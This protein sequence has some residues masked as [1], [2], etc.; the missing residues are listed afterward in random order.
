MEGLGLGLILVVVGLVFVLLVRILLRLLLPGNQTSANLSTSSLTYL[1][2]SDQKDAVIIIQGGGRVEYL[3]ESARRLFGFHEDDQVDLERLTR[4]V[5]PSD[6]FLY[7]L[8]KESQKRISIGAQLTEATSYHVPGLSPLM[9]VVLRNLD[10]APAFSGGEEGQVSASILRLITDFGQS[11]SSNL[12]LKTTLQAILENVGRLISADTIELKVWDEANQCLTPYR[13]EGRSGEPRTLRRVE[14]S[15]FGNYADTLLKTHKPLLLSKTISGDESSTNGMTEPY[16]VRSYIGMPLMDGKDLVGTLEVGQSADDS[17][18]QH[19]LELLHLVAGQAAVAIHN[20]LLYEAEEQRTTELTSLANLAQAVSVSQD[21]K[22]LFERLVKS[23]SPLFDVEIIGFLLYDEGKRTLEGQIPFQGLPPHIVE[24]YRTNIP[25]DKDASDIITS[26]K[27][28]TTLNAAEDET[29]ETLGIRNLAQAASLRDSVLMPLLSGRRLLGFMQLSNHREG[30]V[31][32]SDEELRLI[33][34]VANQA[35]AIIENAVLVQQA[36]QRAY[37]SDA[38]RRI[39]SL[40]ASSASVDE[41][42]EHSVRELA[43]LFQADSAVIFLLDEQNGEL[44]LHTRS[45]FGVEKEAA[46]AISHMFV[47]DAQYRSTVSGSQKPFIS[48]RLSSDRRVLPV[49]RPIVTTLHMESSMVVPLVVRERSLGELM[50]GSRRPEFFNSYDLQVVTTA[51]GQLAS[52]LESARLVSQTDERLRSRVDQLTAIMRVSRELNASLDVDKLL[53]LVHDES[54]RTTRADC[55]T[56]LLFDRSNANEKPEIQFSIGCP[57]DKNLNKLLGKVTDADEALVIADFEQEEIPASHDGIHSAL[58]VPIRKNGDVAGVIHLHASRPNFFNDDIVDLVQTLAVQASIALNTASQYQAEHQRAELLR[59]R[60]ETMSSLTEISY[61]INFEQSLEQQLRNIGNAIRDATPFQAVLFSIFEPDNGMLRRVTGIGFSQEV[62]SELLARKQPLTSI[63]Q[64]LKPEF[65]VSHSYFI[66]ADE[67]PVVPADVHMVTLD[68]KEE[69][70]LENAWDPDDLLILPLSDGQGNPLGLL[71]LD[72][73]NDGLRPDKATIETIEIFA[74]QASLVISNTTRFSDLR[75]RVETLSSGLQRQQRLLSVSQNDLP[76]LLRKDLE[77]TLSIQNLDRRAQRVRAGL[78]I[79]ESVSRQLDASSAL[80]AL[81][82]EVLTQLG[83]SVALVAEEGPEGPRL[84]HILG[85]VPRATNPETLFGQRNPLR[86]CLQMG[87]TILAANEDEADEWLDT[88]LLSG[89]HAKAFICLPVIVQ[90]KTVAAIMAISPEPLPAFTDEDRQVYYQI[91]RQ[92]S[93]ILQNI[94]LLSETR[95]R[96]QEVDLLLDFSRQI[97]GLTPKEIIKALLESARRVI[98]P[99]AHAG[100]VLL[101][102]ENT[103]Q[104]M[105]QTCAGYADNDSLMKIGYRSGEAL[106]GMVFE[107]KSPHR[108]D[109]LNFARDYALTAENLFLYRQATGGRLPVSTLLIPVVTGTQGLG[110]LV[111][112]NF[113]T[114]AAFKPEDETLLLSLT[115]QVALSL[116]NVRLVQATQE[117]AGQLQALNDVATSMTSSLRSEELIASLL[118]Q[119]RPVLPFDTATLLLREKELLRVYAARGFTDSEQRLG[120]TV[121]VA[122]STLFQEMIRVRRPISVAD[123]R[124]D[125]RFPQIETPRLSWLGI[126]LISKGEVIGVITLEKWQ[127]SFYTPDHMQVA[128][129]FAGQAAVA[130]ENAR[131]YEDSVNRAGELDQRSQ[132][133]ALLN[134]FSSQMSGLLDADEIQKVTAEELRKAFAAMRVSVARLDGRTATWTFSTPKSKVELPLQ[135]PDAPI[136]EQLRESLGVFTGE[137]FLREPAV[138]SLTSMLGAEA[139]SMLALPLVSGGSLHSILFLQLPV[140]ERPSTSEIELAITIANQASV[141]LDSARLFQEAQRH[142]Q[143]TMALAEVGRD[144]SATLDLEDVLKR[145][146]TYAKELLKAETSAVY[147]PEPDSNVLHGIAVVGEDAD[148]IRNSPMKVGEGILGSIAER[149]VGEIVNDAENDLRARVIEGTRESL[150]EHLMGVPILSKERFS[151]LMAV[152]RTGKELEFTDV[153]LEFLNNLAQQAGVAIEN[154]RLFAETQRLA[155]ELEQRVIDRT[156]ELEREKANTETLLRI[157]TEVSASLDLDRA[158]SRTLALLNEAVGGEQGTIMLLHAEDN[159]LHYRAGYGYL[160]GTEP[161]EGGGFTLRVGEGLAGWVVETREATLV[162]DLHKDE[163]WVRAGSASGEHRSSIVAPLLVGEDVIG[164]LMVF[165]RKVGYFGPERLGMVKAIAGQVAIAINNAHLYELIR[166]QAERLGSMLRKEQEEASRSQAILEAVADGVVVTGP[167]NRITFLNTSAVEILG[168]KAEKVVKQSLDTFGGIF[169]KAA[170]TWMQTIN[171][172]SNDPVSYQVGDSYAEQL[173]LEDGR[174]ALV[175]LAPVILQNDFLGTVSIFRDITHEVEVDRLKSEFVATVSHELRTP[176]TSIRGYVDIL[177]M[178][179]AGALNEN[180]SHFLHI[181]KNNTE[182]LNIL[183]NDLLDIS[184]IEAG[185]VTL[186]PQPLDLRDV[187]EDVLADILRR[188]QEENKPMAFSLDAPKDLPRV[189]G[190]A[191]RIRQVMGNLVD[192]AYHYTPENGQITVHLHSVNG[193]E[194]QVDVEDSGVGISKEDQARI[195]D[196]FYRGEDPLVLATPGT[197]LG[198]AIVRQLI[199]MH[200][201]RIW[202]KSEGEGQGSTFSFTLPV[203]K[204]GE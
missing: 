1:D 183:V 74:A 59:R 18:S 121:A 182:R 165:H 43:H 98:Q 39:A 132:R 125:T 32:F 23:V 50:L 167:D 104:L 37:R 96:L 100:V 117:R 83:M 48:G 174:I 146:V 70:R 191:E 25:D 81:G 49:Y 160:T 79:T 144:I 41:V 135:L 163:R 15:Y 73:P 56:I 105:P 99:A 201:G 89:L 194:V 153:E 113:N 80:L 42:L 122:D 109:E 138:A 68:L 19:D 47:T 200:D 78:A 179:A 156:A 30:V 106:P 118:D 63:Q 93:V 166:D 136:F 139:T 130:L 2:G 141:A 24:I 202:L 155:E 190:D 67:A 52:A 91:A 157:L 31:V 94:S 171:D 90:E 159:L 128:T 193:S 196:R 54:L 46:D 44:R 123:V 22:D 147:L 60:A 51:A 162:E 13:Y 187:A 9:M 198:L 20:A 87:E 127:S 170:G 53:E 26:Q 65:R 142:A 177:L 58:V 176:M 131:L 76:L 61:A 107:S 203:D 14:R 149:K 184:R 57:P 82:R 111:L 86:A 186:S 175:H 181:V 45:I 16:S 36:R 154:A 97:S 126:P 124:G 108:V 169:G 27:P 133:L 102:D 116:E 35:T 129:T 168:L 188:S 64:L 199:E 4:Y 72:A 143:E 101:W 71:S 137:N 145:I 33:N 192:N 92:T 112:D 180:Q 66:P 8:S 77:Q 40:S 12:N 152:W 29:W 195:F 151:G 150:H 17:F 38:L 21:M 204:K 189:R 10:L 11:I 3:N 7:L 6:E 69:T 134:R 197:G 158:L 120:L 75:N 55:G 110:V 114:Q 140:K 185:R 164:V 178:G 85:S 34:I 148:E 28:L 115:Q 84:L 119:L 5:R 161:T 172:W 95:R 173:E 62:L 88:P 103:S